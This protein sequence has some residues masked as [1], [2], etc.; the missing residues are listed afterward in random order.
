MCLMFHVKVLMH[1]IEM[2]IIQS[3]SFFF[4]VVFHCKLSQN[5]GFPWRQALYMCCL[6][7]HNPGALGCAVSGQCSGPSPIFS[8][9][10]NIGSGPSAGVT[11]LLMK[12][13]CRSLLLLGIKKLQFQKKTHPG[14]FMVRVLPLLQGDEWASLSLS[15]HFQIYSQGALAARRL[16]VMQTPNRKPGASLP[17]LFSPLVHMPFPYRQ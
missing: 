8:Q 11:Q 7:A 6:T 15:P 5:H 1:C 2:N 4:E 9:F 14:T 13:S 16:K 3:Q 17:F 10:S 12:P